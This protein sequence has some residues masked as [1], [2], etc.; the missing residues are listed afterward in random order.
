M[1]TSWYTLHSHPNKENLLDQQVQARGFPVF[2][3]WIRVQPVNPRSRK[4]QPYFPGYIFVYADLE[5]TGITPFERIPYGT[6][7]VMFGGDPPTVPETL[8][9]ALRR[10]IDEI[11]HAGGELVETLVPGDEVH[12]LSGPFQGYDGIFDARLRG[13]ERV[14]ILIKM[15]SHGREIPVELQS[16]QISRK[17]GR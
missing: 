8:I 2:S 6:G 12:I 9:Q 13:A 11:N 15:L 1:S 16:G 17:K 5:V 14:Q 4:I 3:P 10:R 7:L